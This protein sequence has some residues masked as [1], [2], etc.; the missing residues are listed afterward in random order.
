M[1]VG[2]WIGSRK[3]KT[4]LGKTP[5]PKIQTHDARRI[6]IHKGRCADTEGERDERLP[7]GIRDLSDGSPAQD[8][9]DRAL[10]IFAS[11]SAFDSRI[12]I[13]QD[14]N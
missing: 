3:R 6:L 7:K 4:F 9:A 2:V 13:Q 12:N 5:R 1:A 11:A 14:R 8:C 10:L